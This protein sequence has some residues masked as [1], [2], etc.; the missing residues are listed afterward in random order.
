MDIAARQTVFSFKRYC[1]ITLFKFIILFVSGCER[2]VFIMA[3]SYN[4][5]DQGVKT[6]IVQP[7]DKLT[8]CIKVLVSY[9]ID[10]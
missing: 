1:G 6:D 7:F 4:N 10:H 8:Q 9:E 2:S 5:L 3:R